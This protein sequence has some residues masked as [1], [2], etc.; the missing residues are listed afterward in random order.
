MRSEQKVVAKFGGSSMARPVEVMRHL[1][2]EYQPQVVVV[3]APGQDLT[4]RNEPKMTDLLR[5]LESDHNSA[6]KEKVASRLAEICSRYD[7]FSESFTSDFIKEA[8]GQV[9]QWSEARWPV[10]ALGEQWSARLFAQATGRIFLD[11][12]DVIE[13]EDNIVQPAST[14]S[15]IRRAVQP[16]ERYVIPG[17][18]GANTTG[19]VETMSRGGSDITGAIVA[20]ALKQN[21]DIWSDIDGI[22]DQ[23]PRNNPEARLIPRMNYPTAMKLAGVA[24]HPHATQLLEGKGID[25][26]VRN[27]FGSNNGR[28]TV[29]SDAY[30]PHSRLATLELQ[31]SAP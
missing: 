27:T 24:L 5:S 9:E 30:T 11:A 1:H 25:I 22:Y 31:L 29:I 12:A 19:S 8:I 6:T 14:I 26:R 13:I 3:S 10:D 15:S 21:L 17:Y 20:L 7:M 23:D 18:Y 16:N 28:Y 2:N 4:R